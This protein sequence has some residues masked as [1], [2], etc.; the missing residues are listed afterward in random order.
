MIS[1]LSPAGGHPRRPEAAIARAEY[2]AP[3]PAT[4]STGDTTTDPA[5]DADA[6]AGRISMA[7]N[8]PL[9]RLSA[10]QLF[11]RLDRDAKGYLAAADFVRISPAGARAADAAHAKQ[12]ARAQ[13]V[14]ERIDAD[15]D[16]QVSASEFRT[17]IEAFI[18]PHGN[19][20]AL[21][22]AKHAS[23]PPPSPTPPTSPPAAGD[24]ATP[25]DPP[26]DAPVAAP[27][28][29]AASATLGASVAVQTY[30]SVAAAA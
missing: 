18:A 6:G 14:F 8:R 13:E 28:A 25:A 1:T 29:A 9:Y 15:G 2:A 7:N 11:A 16:G 3:R 5:T 17:A 4:P 27:A 23:A 19:G 20:K 24:P 21:G 22:I 10:D 30:A 12:N 26:A